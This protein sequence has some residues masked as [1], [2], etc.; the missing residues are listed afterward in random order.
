VEGAGDVGRGRVVAVN[1]SVGRGVSVGGSG[2]KVETRVCESD[3]ARIAPA[4][5]KG[6][7]VGSALGFGVT[8]TKLCP[9]PVEEGAADGIVQEERMTREKTK[10]VRR[11]F[12]IKISQSLRAMV[13]C[14]ALAP[15][16]ETKRSNPQPDWEIAST[17]RFRHLHLRAGAS[18]RARSA[19]ALLNQRGLATLAPHSHSAALRGLRAFG[20]VQV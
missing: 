4:G 11:C 8:S 12:V 20:A 7:G 13:E 15:C 17:P 6:V 14:G 2:V 16:I 3:G 9:G 1:S 18:V 10:K 5:W 19:L